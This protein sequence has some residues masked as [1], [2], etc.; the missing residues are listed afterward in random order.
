MFTESSGIRVELASRKSQSDGSGDPDVGSESEMGGKK[1]IL[2]LQLNTDHCE[3]YK[4]KHNNDE[5]LEF[6]FDMNNDNPTEVAK[7]MVGCDVEGI[8]I[9]S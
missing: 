5:C 6:E 1:N 2:V 8:K 9:S 4:Q 3:K 7:D